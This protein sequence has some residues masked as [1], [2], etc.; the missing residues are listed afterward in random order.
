MTLFKLVELLS[1]EHVEEYDHN[2]AEIIPTNLWCL[3]T[4]DKLDEIR[5]QIRTLARQRDELSKLLPA[6][7]EIYGVQFVE[8][9]EKL[10]RDL[11]E[12]LS[13]VAD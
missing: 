6:R 11:L 12:Y 1:L 7:A 5:A 8:E 4:Q 13:P 3:E 2:A 10:A 9:V